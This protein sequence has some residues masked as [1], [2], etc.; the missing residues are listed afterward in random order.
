M[1]EDDDSEFVKFTVQQA[2]NLVFYTQS[3]IQLYSGKDYSATLK[4]FLKAVS[5]YKQELVAHG[6][7]C[8][9]SFFHLLMIFW[10]AEKWC[11]DTSTPPPPSSITFPL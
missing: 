9:N 7:G 1:M 11:K 6:I 5:G 10:S 8:Q 3:T 4:V 2:S